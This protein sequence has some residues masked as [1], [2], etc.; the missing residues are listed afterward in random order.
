[1][2]DFKY[3]TDFKKLNIQ[4]W[5]DE[6]KWYKK[7][8][9]NFEHETLINALLYRLQVVFFRNHSNCFFYKET[10]KGKKIDSKEFV[11]ENQ[12]LFRKFLNQSIKIVSSERKIKPII[13]ILPLLKI[14]K[15][16]DI[17]EKNFSATH[18]LL[19]KDWHITKGVVVGASTAVVASMFLSPVIGGYIGNL[20]GF[21]GVAATSYGLAFLGGGSLATG[22]FG[23]AGGSFILGLGFGITN[24]VRGGL[25]GASIDKLN[26]MQAQIYL[27]LLLAIGRLQFENGDEKISKL[28]YTTISQRLKEF[29]KRFKNS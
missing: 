1:M 24:G 28:I 17:I 22:G 2:P 7:Q 4:W 25:K 11:I 19:G 20:A 16:I 18:K 13:D 26:Q 15:K 9:K 8:S 12:K 3:S 10:K 29:E 21:S 5:I 6:I 14:I 27:P 23:M